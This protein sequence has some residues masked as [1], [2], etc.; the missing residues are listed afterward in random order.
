MKKEKDEKIK[1]QLKIFLKPVL[2]SLLVLQKQQHETDITIGR[3]GVRTQVASSLAR[4]EPS[5]A[6]ISLDDSVCVMDEIG[7]WGGRAEAR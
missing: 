2:D 4:G 3:R 7:E 6:S 5:I 1:I